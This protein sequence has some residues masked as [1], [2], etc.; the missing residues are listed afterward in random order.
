MSLAR[1]LLALSLIAPALVAGA[2]ARASELERLRGTTPE[3]R[4]SLQTEFMQSRLALSGPTLEAVRKL[5]LDTAKRLQPVIEGKESTLSEIAQI[6][7]IQ[8]AK[9]AELGK[10]LTPE[11]YSRYRSSQDDLKAYV[12]SGLERERGGRSP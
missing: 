4:A 2:P 12:E 9:D 8:A 6:R 10:L 5:N 3:Q 1:G 11:Q 7:K